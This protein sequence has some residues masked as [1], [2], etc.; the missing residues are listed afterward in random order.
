VAV[1]EPKEEP[2]A[3]GPFLLLPVLEE[4]IEWLGD[5][6][7][8]ISSRASEIY[9]GRTDDSDSR[10]EEHFEERQPHGET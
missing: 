8:R 6:V 3:S 7:E 10:R 4:L 9:I 1:R 5:K 2:A